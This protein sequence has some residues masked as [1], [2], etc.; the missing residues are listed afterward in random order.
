[1]DGRLDDQSFEHYWKDIGLIMDDI[2]QSLGAKG[3]L[4]SLKKRKDQIL[5]PAEA[6][7]PRATFSAFQV[8]VLAAA[9]IA[10]EAVR[11]LKALAEEHI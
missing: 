10:M 4:N 11:N 2:E 5:S 7:S 8:D 6:Q 1:M 9:N 3:Y